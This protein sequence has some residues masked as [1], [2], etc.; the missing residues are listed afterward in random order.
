MAGEALLSIK[1]IQDQWQISRQTI[2]TAI[3]EKKLQGKKDAKSKRWQFELDEVVRWKGEPYA[4]TVAPEAVAVAGKPEADPEIVALLKQQLEEQKD[5][6][7]KQL[8][9]KDKE[10]ERLAVQIDRKDEQI[11]HHQNLLE[12]KTKDEKKGWLKKVF[13]Q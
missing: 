3:K 4:K 2:Q 13:G 11:K 5:N 1:D 8:E 10:I 12:D 7:Q 6:H 9:D